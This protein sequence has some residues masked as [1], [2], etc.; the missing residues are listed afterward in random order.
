V[1]FISAFNSDVDGKV[2]REKNTKK[3]SGGKLAKHTFGVGNVVFLL[4]V[5]S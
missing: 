4:S 5:C 3:T 2:P 1:V